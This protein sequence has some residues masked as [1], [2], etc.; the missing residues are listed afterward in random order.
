MRRTRQ[1]QL[2]KSMLGR[3][4]SR[5]GAPQ[6]EARQGALPFKAVPRETAETA[7]AQLRAAYLLFV[8]TCL[9]IVNNDVR[10][11]EP[12]SEGSQKEPQRWSDG[13]VIQENDEE[14]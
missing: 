13:T 6:S 5:A 9:E 7:L 8:D 1:V 4:G 12:F 11:V 10:Y 2:T 3:E 14:G